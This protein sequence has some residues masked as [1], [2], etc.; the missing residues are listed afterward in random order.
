METDPHKTVRSV[1]TVTFVV[2]IGFVVVAIV[3]LT[4][5]ARIASKRVSVQIRSDFES[6]MRDADSVRLSR[7]DTKEQQIIFETSD[8][9]VIEALAYNIK[10]SRY[11]AEDRCECA[12]DVKFE[13]YREGG[14]TIEF[15]FHHQSKIRWQGFHR[16]IKLKKESREFLVNWLLQ[17]IKDEELKKRFEG[18][19]K[20]HYSK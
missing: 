3:W 12:G 8:R 15:T 2:F 7:P 10:L 11:G 5:A 6:A 18:P 13:F 17:N 20:E 19:L 16:D 4:A 1:R 14:L 9:N